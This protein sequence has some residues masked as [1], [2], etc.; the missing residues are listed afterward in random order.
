MLIRDTA[1][2]DCLPC[3]SNIDSRA[4]VECLSTYDTI[5]NFIMAFLPLRTS[6]IIS[7]GLKLQY[8][9]YEPEP[10]FMHV[11]DSC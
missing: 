5:Y 7:Y 6:S 4:K 1:F 10:P 11:T 3:T 2:R 8:D 9:F